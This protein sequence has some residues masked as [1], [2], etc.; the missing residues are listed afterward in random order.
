MLSKRDIIAGLAV[1]SLATPVM[2]QDVTRAI[3]GPYSFS[4]VTSSV[5]TAQIKTGAGL[6]HS[7]TVNTPTSQ[8]TIA[9]YD[10]TS[11]GG[12]QIVNFSTLTGTAPFYTEYDVQFFAGLFASWSNSSTTNPD[13]TIAYR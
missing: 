12:T 3:L 8:A 4:R 2:A 1:G 10:G 7:I 9:L 13:I 6:L 11:S 5:G